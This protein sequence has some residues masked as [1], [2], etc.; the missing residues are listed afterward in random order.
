[1]DGWMDALYKSFH[2]SILMD[3]SKLMICKF[4]NVGFM[5]VILVTNNKHGVVWHCVYA[6]TNIGFIVAVPA[7]NIAPLQ[8]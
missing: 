2:P 8:L 4:V 6:K 3:G 1:M 5:H 7:G